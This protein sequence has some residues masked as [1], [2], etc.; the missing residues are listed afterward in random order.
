MYWKEI[1]KQ[2]WNDT[3][4]AKA[5]SIVPAVVTTVSTYG[6]QWK[7][8]VRLSFQLTTI[9]IAI[10]F[11]TYAVIMAGD[12]MVEFFRKIGNDQESKQKAIED[13][14]QKLAKLLNP[15]LSEK[16][17]GAIEKIEL[18]IAAADKIF[19][20]RSIDRETFETWS[21]GTAHLLAKTISQ[22]SDCYEAFEKTQQNA[23]NVVVDPIQC[24]LQR[25]VAILRDIINEIRR[26]RILVLPDMSEPL[27]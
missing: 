26:R 22:S 24:N 25:K 17:R 5:R 13:S 6:L 2:A 7:L 4:S 20:T 19:A 12:F 21:N 16:E 23:D 15:E 27:T 18:M 10:G 14:L 9:C 8:G 3:V 11:V 1:A